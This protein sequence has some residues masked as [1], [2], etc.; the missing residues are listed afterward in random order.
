MPST[1]IL[2]SGSEIRRQMLEQAGVSC[3]AIP[4]RIDETS[5]KSALMAEKATPRD[6]A[7][8]LAE[9][10]SRKISAKNPEALTIGCDQ[11]LSFDGA[12]LSK[13]VDEEDARDQLQRLRGQQ[14]DLFSAVVICQN[15]EPQWRSVGHVRLTMHSF[16][17]AFLD[18]Y[19]S[20]NWPDVADSV[21]AY[22]LEHEGARLFSRVQ[23]DYFTVL[24][25]PLLETL[26]YLGQ[27]GAIDR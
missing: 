1:I 23:G 13:P 25:L 16:S 26:T 2:A 19:L 18:G 12:I 15:A 3:V 9:L 27:R 5:V 17:D 7:D 10:K 6:I 14:H 4:P 20:R 24:G 22:K 21:G 11:V 8:S